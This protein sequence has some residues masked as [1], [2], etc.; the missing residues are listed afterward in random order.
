M[1]AQLDAAAASGKDIANPE[2]N[3]T[4]T[5]PEKTEAAEVKSEPEVK[6]D[7]KVEAKAEVKP[8]AKAEPKKEDEAEPDWEKAPPK[9]GRLYRQSETKF[10]ATIKTLE[11]KIKTLDSKSN[12]TAADASKL[13][14]YEKQ[15]EELRNESKTYKQQ[16][17]ERDYTK[18]DEYAGFQ[19]RATAAYTK[20]IDLVNQLKVTDG[21]NV[22]QAVRADF[23]RL[24]MLPLADRLEAA[25][26][27]FGKY[28][29]RVLSYVDQIDM[30]NDEANEAA[31]N[32]AATYEK[33]SLEQQSISKK[34]QA[35]YEG[36]YKSALD[37]IQ[38]NEN[39]GKWF[40]PDESDPEAS[41]LLQDSYD[42]IERITNQIEKLPLDQQA[43]Y[44]AVYRAR[45]AAA[46]RLIMAVNRI[47]SER[48][49]LKA[50]LAKLRG[51][52]PGAKGKQGSE[53]PKGEKSLGI[54]D[55]A[56]VFDQMPR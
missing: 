55:A 23:D 36:F 11:D 16:L 13:E 53:S 6:T 14:A 32:H 21:D 43:A 42:E 18:T 4:T 2:A 45:A 50:E 47:T 17:A 35:E 37:G 5:A 3:T 34:Q 31:K 29:N 30:I 9:W 10:K 41:K 15:L 39:Y 51:T 33:K 46:P 1:M 7:P 19:K 20:G 12:P 8:D 54:A 28:A 40:K 26:N 49:A 48:D 22:R 44:A 52:D 24:R 38:S 25:E 27:M 56:A